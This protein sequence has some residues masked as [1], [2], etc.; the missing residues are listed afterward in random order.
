[1]KDQG[2]IVEHLKDEDRVYSIEKILDEWDG[3]T[4]IS[5]TIKKEEELPEDGVPAENFAAN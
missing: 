3:I 5:L 2:I 1:M 4:G